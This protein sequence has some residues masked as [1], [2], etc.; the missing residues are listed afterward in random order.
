MM[1]IMIGDT[2]VTDDREIGIVENRPGN[3]LT[4]RFP[5]YG[6]RRDQVHYGHH[7]PR[8]DAFPQHRVFQV[9]VLAWEG[10]VHRR[11]PSRKLKSS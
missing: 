3:T 8:V 4:V 9:R 1:N 6:N 5:D 2:I 10:T 11:A 7:Q